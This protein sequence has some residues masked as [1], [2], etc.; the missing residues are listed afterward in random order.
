M[1]VSLAILAYL[2]QT[3]LASIQKRACV[4]DNCA[5]AVTGTRRGPS[6]TLTASSD[7]SSFL[8][9]TTTI[10]LSLTTIELT[11]T[12]TVTLPLEDE[13][14]AKRAEPSPT[15]T[16]KAIPSY[17]SACS[18]AVRYSSACACLGITAFTTTVADE[19]RISS[20]LLS[21][22]PKR[23]RIPHMKDAHWVGAG[24]NHHSNQLH[25]HHD[26][27][28]GFIYPDFHLYGSPPPP[29]THPHDVG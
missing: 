29:S 15:T 17:A 27:R 19:V 2:A 28:S 3:G 11:E 14:L 16:S 25:L 5:R 26:L 4:A 9:E 21:L 23:E 18:G 10:P 6:H 7:C 24:G 20:I 22:S 1:R 12:R 8:H 13:G